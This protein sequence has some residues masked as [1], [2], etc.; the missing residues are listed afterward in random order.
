M[1]TAIQIANLKCVELLVSLIK[2]NPGVGIATLLE[3]LQKDHSMM[4]MPNDT[5]VRWV[6]NSKEI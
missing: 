4:E 6:K 5:L 3:H 1:E 2:Q